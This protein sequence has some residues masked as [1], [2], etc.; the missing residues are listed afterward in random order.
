MIKLQPLCRSGRKHSTGD[1]AGNLGIA[2]AMLDTSHTHGID[3]TINTFDPE[4]E[5]ADLRR[6]G[7]CRTADADR[8]SCTARLS[9]G[10]RSSG[11]GWRAIGP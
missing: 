9:S 1:V 11:A 6:D 4:I 3:A 5:L 7:E 8:T 10:P 2:R